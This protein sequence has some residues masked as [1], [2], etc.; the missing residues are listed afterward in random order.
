MKTHSPILMILAPVGAFFT[1]KSNNDSV[2]LNADTYINWI[3]KIVGIR[4][5]RHLTKKEV[6]IEDP[7]YKQESDNLNLLCDKCEAYI[8]DNK[9]KRAPN[10]LTL[11]KKIDNDEDIVDI[12]KHLEFIIEKLANSN[13]IKVISMVCWCGNLFTGI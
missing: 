2:V 6:I 12:N 8:S 9:L 4:D 1:Y 3:R 13:N 11:W 5:T 7:D 10:Y